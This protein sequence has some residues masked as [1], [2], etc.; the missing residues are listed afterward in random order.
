MKKI[1][2]R[3]ECGRIFLESGEIKIEVCGYWERVCFLK[4]SNQE[5][6]SVFRLM[7]NIDPREISHEMSKVF[8]IRKIINV[9]RLHIDGATINVNLD[10]KKSESELFE[11]W[12]N[13]ANKTC[14]A[15]MIDEE[16]L[17]RFKSS[18]IQRK[19]ERYKRMVRENDELERAQNFAI[20]W[21][22]LMQREKEK[23]RQ[24]KEVAFETSAIADFEVVSSTQ[25]IIALMMLNEVWYWGD[26]LIDIL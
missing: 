10:K 19:F 12:V 2:L 22:K 16:E 13:T 7:E 25:F 11:Q 4:A 15:E 20:R 17:L 6:I 8:Q 21:A 3:E 26:E 5:I 23:G 1:L 24:I 14:E 9:I 18:E